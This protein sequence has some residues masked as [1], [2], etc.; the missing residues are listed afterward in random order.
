[1]RFDDVKWMGLNRR[2]RW[3]SGV[4]Y[5]K[6]RTNV[7]SACSDQSKGEMGQDKDV[8]MKQL[9]CE[10]FRVSVQQELAQ[11]SLCGGGRGTEETGSS[12]ELEERNTRSSRVSQTIERAGGGAAQ[13][14]SK[15]Y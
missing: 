8:K 13:S 6:R 1:M 4:V 10:E 3:N 5:G 14:R 11:Y 2:R 15:S 12:Y 9:M 7:V